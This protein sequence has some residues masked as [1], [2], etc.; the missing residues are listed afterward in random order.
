MG[1]WCC[2]C[3]L[4]DDDRFTKAGKQASG[5][6]AGAR[7]ND[8]TTTAAAADQAQPIAWG[9]V[10]ARARALRLGGLPR[11][12]LAAETSKRAGDDVDG[13]DDGMG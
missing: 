4:C 7:T 8:A 5:W 11:K 10:R 6:T 13:D 3:V 12:W 1:L 2:V 9:R